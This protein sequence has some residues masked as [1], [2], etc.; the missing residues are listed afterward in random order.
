LKNSSAAL[1]VN[2]Q[3]FISGNASTGQTD[4][5]IATVSKSHVVTFSGA[6]IVRVAN[7]FA[8]VAVSPVD[9]RNHVAKWM[10]EHLW[11]SMGNLWEE[12]SA[13]L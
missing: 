2:V 4:P 3:I 1:D 10:S 5:G 12:D 13:S 9:G 7:T 11:Y 6:K 8:D